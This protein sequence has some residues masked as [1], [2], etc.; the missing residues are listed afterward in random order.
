[1]KKLVSIMIPTFN[2]A[3][4]VDGA[5]E[6]ALA[7]DYGNLEVL[8][9]DNGST[10][11]TAEVVGS[12]AS[13]TR[14]RYVRYPENIGSA[15]NFNNALMQHAR[16][17]YVLMLCDDDR[18]TDKSYI[19]KAMRLIESDQEVVLVFAN[20]RIM[21]L[22]TQTVL[23]ETR[24]ALQPNA[25]I[26][27]RWLWLN[28]WQGIICGLLTTLY[29]RKIGMQVGGYILETMGSDT[30]LALNILLHGKGGFIADV[31]ADYNVHSASDTK[32]TRDMGVLYRGMDWI[33]AGGNYACRKGIAEDEVRSWKKR[34]LTVL[35]TEYVHDPC[36]LELAKG[37]RQPLK[38]LLSMAKEYGEQDCLLE[39]MASMLNAVL[40]KL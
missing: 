10:D 38:K 34:L 28:Y 31:V 29:S 36:L 23:G 35:L 16:G 22:A 20:Y 40:G 24:I 21:D 5:I 30:L 27:G 15:A 39:A 14:L 4:L 32:M 12:F 9:S 17:E 13:D 33:R 6:S 8:V 3:N 1:M 2:R 19:S 7:Q 18:L 26:E 25:I 37:N 11:N